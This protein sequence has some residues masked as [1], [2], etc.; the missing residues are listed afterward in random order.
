MSAAG[1]DSDIPD[2]DAYDGA[3][4]PRF[5]Q[6]LYGHLP[7]E[8]EMLNA[9][10]TGR[11]A[12][13]WLIGGA[14][15]VGKATLAWR[16]ARFLLSHPDPNSRAVSQA[17]DL[18]VEDSHPAA[19]L[20]AGHAHPDFALLRREWDAKTKKHFTLIRVD[21]VREKLG[22]FQLSAAYGGW[23]VAIVDAA[24]DLNV[25]SANA[26]LKV[27]EEPPPRSLILII[28]HRPG[29]VLPTIR[30]RCRRLILEPLTPENV[31]NV[32]DG[33]GAPWATAGED[34]IAAA[35]ARADGS[36]R[37]ALR[38]LDPKAQEIGALID[39]AIARLPQSD[40]QVVIKIADAVAGRESEDN[41]ERFTLA[42]FDWLATQARQ[43][44]TP[45]RLEAIA[46]LWRVLRAQTDETEA[47]NLDK[48][49]HVVA[50]FEAIAQR[51]RALRSA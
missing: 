34:R 28:A 51:G 2:S 47:V 18:A 10:R 4:H 38:W 25:A 23:R 29:Q 33:L 40:P 43:P 37:E 17:R 45:A 9:Y 3:P 50:L 31:V 14:P 15:G 6:R 48:R 46:D 20:L 30:S 11:L 44:S 7:A 36:V 27:I 32:V 16:F 12:H 41:F 21:D 42:I 26:L 5:A 35:A 24:D 1:R 49:V 8:T 19:R 13:A 22:V 39:R